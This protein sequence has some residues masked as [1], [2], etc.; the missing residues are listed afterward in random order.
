MSRIRT[1]AKK[2]KTPS[3]WFPATGL[4][5]I[6]FALF[7]PDSVFFSRSGSTA[8]GH[9]QFVFGRSEM[10]FYGGVWSLLAA[11]KILL[12]KD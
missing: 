2:I 6:I 10:L 7:A 1:A 11:G 12:R 8:A 3:W 4:V 5:I 9:Y